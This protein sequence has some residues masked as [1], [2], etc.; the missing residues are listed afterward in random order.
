MIREP[1]AMDT[2]D[3]IADMQGSGSV[4]EYVKG[5][6]DLRQ[7]CRRRGFRARSGL[8]AKPTDGAQLSIERLFKGGEKNIT[9]I[10]RHR[11]VGLERA[12]HTYVRMS[13]TNYRPT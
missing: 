6:I 3:Q 4:R 10:V 2:L 12:C 11:G 1:G 7:T 8:T 9:D 5:Q 13:I